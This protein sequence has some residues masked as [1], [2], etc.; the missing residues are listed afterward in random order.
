MLQYLSTVAKGPA[1]RLEALG[2]L[3]SALFDLTPGGHSH[4]KVPLW[5]KCVLQMLEVS[6]APAARL[7]G[8]G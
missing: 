6:G 3:V 8:R 4:M 5:K 1:Q 2:Q 7:W